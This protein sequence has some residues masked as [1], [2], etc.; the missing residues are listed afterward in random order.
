M[1]ALTWL[2][3]EA[4]RPGAD[5]QVINVAIWVLVLIILGALLYGVIFLA[6]QN[7]EDKMHASPEKK[8]PTV[9]SE[10]PRTPEL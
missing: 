1:V 3:Q 5:P 4:T 2:L 6:R 8:K 9:G 7:K 10:E